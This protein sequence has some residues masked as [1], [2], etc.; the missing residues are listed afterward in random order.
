MVA[1]EKAAL[2]ELGVDEATLEQ[3]RAQLAAKG[4]T[5]RV[6]P[7]TLGEVARAE[8]TQPRTRKPRS[9]K[10]THKPAKDQAAGTLNEKQW[11]HIAVLVERVTLSAV[12]LN[13]ARTKHDSLVAEY[14]DYLDGLKK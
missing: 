8:E 12:Y 10:G 11:A 1:S 9:D 4:V 13:D 7:M 3:R 6:P 2:Q 14:R 5:A